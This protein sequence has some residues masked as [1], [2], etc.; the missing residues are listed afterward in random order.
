MKL[1]AD[2]NLSLFPEN[3]N[4]VHI[5]PTHGAITEHSGAPLLTK[6]QH[7]SC[8]GLKNDDNPKSWKFINQSFF[9]LSCTLEDILDYFPWV[10][11]IATLIC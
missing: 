6:K 7:L 3:T 8:T 2:E 9:Q 1:R 10:V 11:N 4:R 5:A